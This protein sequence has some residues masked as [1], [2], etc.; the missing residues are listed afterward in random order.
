MNG[1]VYDIYEDNVILE[2]EQILLRP[3]Y[4]ADRQAIFDN[5]Y[6]DQEVGRYFLVGYKETI[7]EL[8][9]ERLIDN[10]RQLK[11]FVFAI[12]IKET[13]EVIGMINQTNNT[14]YYS[15]YI[16]IGYAIGSRYWNHGYTTEALKLF[17]DFCFRKGIY[18]VYCGYITENIASKRVM[19]KA[20]MEYE[21]TRKK[22]IF[23]HD[24]FWDVDYYSKEN[25][26]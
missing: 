12:V 2:S 13:G 17:I 23:L 3:L 26:L 11:L 25:S 4:P 21:F 15:R 14:N 7:D 6:H 22:E 8:N 1:P 9:L 5:I 19:E 20:G 24:R 16:E 10:Y 18:K